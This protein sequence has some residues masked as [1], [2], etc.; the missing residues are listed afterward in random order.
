MRT[1]RGFSGGFTRAASLREAFANELQRS[2]GT[3]NPLGC[4]YFVGDGRVTV[5]QLERNID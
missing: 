4:L 2:E 3:Q 1:S 5:A